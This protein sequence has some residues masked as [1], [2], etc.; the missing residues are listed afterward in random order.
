M[1]NLPFRETAREPIKDLCAVSRTG[2]RELPAI[3]QGVL[4]VLRYSNGFREDQVN[5][6]R[7]A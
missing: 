1:A 3:L 6:H 2:T 5:I 7:L 4:F